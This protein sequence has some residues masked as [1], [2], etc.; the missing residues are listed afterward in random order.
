MAQVIGAIQALL[1]SG[2]AQ[3]RSKPEDGNKV[4]VGL[5]THKEIADRNKCAADSYMRSVQRT[6]KYQPAFGHGPASQRKTVLDS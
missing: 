6:G 5:S 1:N 4:R 3:L 2:A